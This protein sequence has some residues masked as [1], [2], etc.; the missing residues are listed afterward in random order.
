MP[1]INSDRSRVRLL[2]LILLLMATLALF[3]F[4]ERPPAEGDMSN[5]SQV[6]PSTLATQYLDKLHGIEI[7]ASTQMAPGDQARRLY[8]HHRAPQGQDQ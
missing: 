3:W 5:C 7:G 6:G 4:V 1:P 2:V 8:L